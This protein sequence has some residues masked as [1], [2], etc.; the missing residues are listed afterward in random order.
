MP[1]DYDEISDSG[2]PLEGQGRVGGTGRC[3]FRFSS[4]M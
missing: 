3:Y 1:M 2:S 4:G